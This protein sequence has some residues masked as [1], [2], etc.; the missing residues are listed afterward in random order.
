[1]P[2]LSDFELKPCPRVLQVPRRCCRP[3][4]SP[5]L[6]H[7]DYNLQVV[8]SL[9]L[10]LEWLELVLMVVVLVV[11]VVVVLQ[12]PPPVPRA[13]ETAIW[14]QDDPKAAGRVLI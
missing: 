1:M 3:K 7:A 4:G 9:V 2:D 6:Q 11:L 10:G 13:G 12:L 8:V 14:C 5:G